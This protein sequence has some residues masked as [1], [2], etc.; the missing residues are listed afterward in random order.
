VRKTLAVVRKEVLQIVRDPLTLAMLLGLPAFML[1]VVGYAVNFDVEGLQLAVQNRDPGPASRRLIDS[2]TNS[3]RFELVASIDAATDIDLILKRRVA[4]AVL[5]IPEDFGENLAAGRD[6]EVQL[7][8][9]GSDSNT[10]T[11]ALGYASGVIQAANGELAA[12]ALRRG[13]GEALLETAI[14]LQSRVWFNPELRSSHFLVP[15]LIGF[16]LM[17]TGVLSTALAV[18]REKESGTMEQ[19]GVAPL[20]PIQVLLGKTIPYMV[21]SLTATVLI[22]VAARVLFGVVVH[23]SYVDLFAITA[24]YLFGALAFGLLISSLVESQAVAFQ[25]G[26]LS[27]MLPALILSGFIF[28]IR[29]M[30]EPLQLLSLIVPARYYLV[31]LRGVILKGAGL[32]PYWE[33]VAALGIYTTVVLSLAVLRYQRSGV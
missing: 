24:L 10:A 25:M 3:R 1:V 23:G 21:V 12:R 2:F 33:Q 32:A 4:R 26:I 11:T 15:G 7:I 18:V 22:L 28:P 6:A 9:D 16:I 5:V 27:S 30:P 20:H 17:I 31:V 29:N 8:I 14:D 13:G 19:L